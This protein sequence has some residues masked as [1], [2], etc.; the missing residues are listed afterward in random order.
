[1]DG[2]GIATPVDPSDGSARGA[3]WAPS[4]LN[5]VERTRSYARTA[6]YDLVAA[7]R[8]NYHILP[9]IATTE[10]LF[11]ESSKAIGVEYVIRDNNKTF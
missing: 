2:L 1:L 9:M 3:F 10:I 11:D 7:T 5:T 6:H 4:T 8:P